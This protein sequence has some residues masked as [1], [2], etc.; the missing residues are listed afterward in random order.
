MEAFRGELLEG[1]ADAGAEFEPLAAAGKNGGPAPLGAK[2]QGRGMFSAPVLGLSPGWAWLCSN[3][4][5]YQELANAFKLGR[6]LAAEQAQ[7][8]AGAEGCRES[9]LLL[10]ASD[11]AARLQIELEKV[12]KLAYAAWMLSGEST[13]S[14]GPWK[15]PADLLPQPQVFNNR[16]GVLRA[17]MGRQGNTLKAHASSVFPGAALILP[18]LIYEAADTIENSRRFSRE[19]LALEKEQEPQPEKPQAPPLSETEPAQARKAPDSSWKG[20]LML[21]RVLLILLVALC[22]FALQSCSSWYFSM[23]L[24]EAGGQPYLVLEHRASSPD[25]GEIA[26]SIYRAKGRRP[27]GMGACRDSR[28]WGAPMVFSPRGRTRSQ[29]KALRSS[30]ARRAGGGNRS[31]EQL[32]FCIR[33][34]SPSTTCRRSPRRST[35]ELLPFSWI[36]ETVVRLRPGRLAGLWRGLAAV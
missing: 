36:A 13:L 1:L 29:R 8:E 15:V 28:G 9:G 34:A 27:G 7:R 20:A 6:T 18:Y 3:S 19:A 10:G 31:P 32:A 4:A 35:L 24:A 23:Q 17:G 21:Q 22:V 33:I 12:V 11:D 14:A 16:M 2:F 26:F 5:A 25:G 30:S